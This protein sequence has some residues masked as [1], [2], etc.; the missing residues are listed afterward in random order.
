MNDHSWCGGHGHCPPK[1]CHDFSQGC[2]I[3]MSGGFYGVSSALAKKMI[4]HPNLNQ[5]KKGIEDLRTGHLVKAVIET[6]K[7][8]QNMLQLSNWENG[9]HW[10]HFKEKS[11]VTFEYLSGQRPFTKGD[12]YKRR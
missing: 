3:Y 1:G 4:N 12:C 5:F 11:N 2:W 7:D 8:P 6:E 9:V 10:C